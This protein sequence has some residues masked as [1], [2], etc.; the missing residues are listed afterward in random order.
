M[1]YPKDVVVI[2]HENFI[3]TSTPGANPKVAVFTIG[4][5][6][7]QRANADYTADS[8]EEAVH[9]IANTLRLAR[10]WNTTNPDYK[11]VAEGGKRCI[12]TYDKATG[13]TVLADINSLSEDELRTIETLRGINKHF[14]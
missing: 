2:A 7:R 8:I 12:L 1:D 10:I 9:W 4:A 6:Y 5:D 11:L 14:R 13:A 3:I